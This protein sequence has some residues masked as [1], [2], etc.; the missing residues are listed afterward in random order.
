MIRIRP[1]L[2]VALILV[3]A[4]AFGEAYNREVVVPVMQNNLAQIRAIGAGLEAMDY[5]ALGKS[6]FSIADGMMK[7]LPMEPPKGEEAHWT[8]TLTEVI[9]VAYLG[10]GAC[11]ARYAAGVQDAFDRLRAL[12]QEGHGAHRP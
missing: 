11:G 10:V 2:F 6:F 4:F 7:V 3:G 5:F 12:M 9:N 8:A 1:L